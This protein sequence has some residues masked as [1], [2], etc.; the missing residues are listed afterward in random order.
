MVELE[1]AVAAEVGGK[2]RREETGVGLVEERRPAV[3]LNET[4]FVLSTQ[5]VLW[6]G[7]VGGWVG[8]RVCG[9]EGGTSVLLNETEFVLG[10]EIFLWS[11]WVGG[12]G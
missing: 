5:I 7:W 3:L 8:G 10:G 9:E 1:E 4:E 6:S 11:E 12:R 2:G